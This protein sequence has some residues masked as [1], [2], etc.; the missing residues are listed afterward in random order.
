[1]GKEVVD[2]LLSHRILNPPASQDGYR[3]V[4]Q[5]IDL[6]ILNQAAHLSNESCTAMTSTFETKPKIEKLINCLRIESSGDGS[7][8]EGVLSATG[9][10]ALLSIPVVDLC[11]NMLADEHTCYHSDH[12]ISSCLAHGI[13]AETFHMD[14]IFGFIN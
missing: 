13:Y 14:I 7:N 9:S 10:R 3:T 8:H 11:T 4:N 2:R 6:S 5:M 1:M 12:S